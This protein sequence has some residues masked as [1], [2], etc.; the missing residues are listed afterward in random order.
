MMGGGTGEK[1][2]TD[3]NALLTEHAQLAY[4][5]VK[6]SDPEF[7]L[8]IREELDPNISQIE[9]V[10]QDIGRVFVN[11]V[12]NACYATNERRQEAIINAKQAPDS[13]QDAAVTPYIPILTLTTKQTEDH[14]EIHVRDNGKGMPPEVIAKIFNPFFTTKPTDKGTGLGLALSNDII[15]EHGGSIQV[16]SKPDEFTEMTIRIPKDPVVAELNKESSDQATATQTEVVEAPDTESQA[17][18][19]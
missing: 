1:Y 11:M 6:A 18:S 16:N 7:R 4:H 13:P 14:I 15:R 17:L 12:T 5:S 19:S 9:V 3:L 10:P 2:F 8:D